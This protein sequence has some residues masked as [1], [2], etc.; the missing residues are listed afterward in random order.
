[1]HFNNGTLRE[2][3]EAALKLVT[4]EWSSA[5]ELKANEI[6]L[7]ALAKKGVIERQDDWISLK[8]GNSKV[9]SFRLT[10]KATTL[11]KVS[12]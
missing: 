1:M 5:L 12:S 11:E 6:P 4:N 10:Q 3:E 7:I 9:R 8:S 2:E